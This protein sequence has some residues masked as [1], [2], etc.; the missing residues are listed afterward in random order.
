MSDRKKILVID[1]DPDVRQ[2]IRT[3]AE[4]YGLD[5]AIACDGK[6]AQESLLELEQY[7]AVFLDLLMPYVSGWE[8]LDSIKSSPFGEQMPVVIISGAPISGKEKENL[9]QKVTAFVSKETFSLK[10]FE[11]LFRSVMD[12]IR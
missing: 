8:V 11:E 5:V 7:S 10:V 4:R 3:V 12:K 2:I 9:M 1:D 6:K